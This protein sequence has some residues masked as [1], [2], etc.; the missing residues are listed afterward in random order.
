MSA[1]RRT[2]PLAYTATFVLAS[3]LLLGGCEKAMRDMYD[4]AKDKPLDANG[5]FEDGASARP[6]VAGTVAHL[7]GR[8]AGASS[9]RHGQRDE[10]AARPTVTPVSEPSQ[11]P[12]GPW[13]PALNDLPMSVTRALLERGRERYEIYCVP[14]HSPV[15]DG[16]GIVPRRGFV[17]PPSY[18]TDR[19]RYAPD[20]HF[21]N[22]ITSGY[23]AM[24]PYGDRVSSD[25]RWAIVAYIRALQLSQHAAA[26]TLDA[27]L[28]AR[29]A[30]AV[31]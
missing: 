16:D 13:M 21:Y 5:L 6:P 22:V 27:S 19:L 11:I 7:S 2:G 25:D 10:S 14:C 26:E 30:A 20:Q 29:L 28:R 3:T 31:P 4:Q 15:G 24:F 18:H 9:G 12:P 17:A 1:L 23:G 8:L